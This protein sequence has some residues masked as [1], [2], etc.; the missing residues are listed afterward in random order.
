MLTALNREETNCQACSGHPLCHMA[1]KLQALTKVT[2]GREP[3]QDLGGLVGAWE[4][5]A[6]QGGWGQHPSVCPAKFMVTHGGAQQDHGTLL[7]E[8]APLPGIQAR[9]I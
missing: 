7:S 6:S 9:I 8:N 1:G 5:A 3:S 4:E 2:G